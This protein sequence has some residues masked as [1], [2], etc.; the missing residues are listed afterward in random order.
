M[1]AKTTLGVV[2][3]SSRILA[4]KKRKRKVYAV[5]RHDGSLG[6]QKQSKSVLARPIILDVTPAVQA[7]AN[8]GL[9]RNLLL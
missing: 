9:H 2:Y 1:C 7:I 8:V 5:E 6:T 4:K 3:W